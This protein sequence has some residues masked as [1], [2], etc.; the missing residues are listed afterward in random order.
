MTYRPPAESRLVVAV[1]VR[2]AW[3]LQA[4]LPPQEKVWERTKH[5]TTEAR[6]EL[7]ATIDTMRA[8]ANVYLAMQR[9]DADYGTPAAEDS[10]EPA[11]CGVGDERL[12]DRLT[13]GDVAGLLGISPRRVRQLAGAGR[14][15]GHRAGPHWQFTPE[16]VHRY[17][18][19]RRAA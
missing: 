12:A 6:R 16:A 14:I 3:I 2:T 11:E 9:R 10:P 7:L 1:S 18:E 4:L 8:A 17:R 19:L 13:T 5:L 15:E